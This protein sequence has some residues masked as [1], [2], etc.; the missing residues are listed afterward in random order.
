MVGSTG[1]V[2]SSRMLAAFLNGLTMPSLPPPHTPKPNTSMMLPPFSGHQPFCNWPNTPSS[3][4][5]KRILVSTT[6]AAWA[7]GTETPKRRVSEYL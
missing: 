3:S 6:K 2:S 4:L 1:A 7:I 5:G